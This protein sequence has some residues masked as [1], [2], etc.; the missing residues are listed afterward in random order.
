MNTSNPNLNL[1]RFIPHRPLPRYAFVPN[2]TPH[3]VSDP[4]GHS[5]GIQ[6]AVPTALDVASWPANQTYLYG[7]DLFNACYFWESHVEWES[8]WLAS[9]RH[10]A[11]ADFLK[12]LIH[13]AA[14][15]VKHLEGR[16]AGVKSHASRAAQLWRNVAQIVGPNAAGFL[17]L[18]LGRWIQVADTIGREGWPPA[19]IVLLP[20]LP[21]PT[22]DGD[23]G[24][25]IA[26]EGRWKAQDPH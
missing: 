12:G 26:K 25:Q 6:P 14:A 18:D 23:F 11:L 22:S 4:A 20:A 16:L 9:G 10:G 1:P 15:G 5:F 2:R 13:L 7:I 17:G 19:P 24:T 3:P 21:A 8:L